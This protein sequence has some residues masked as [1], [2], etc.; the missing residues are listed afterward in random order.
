MA[1][2]NYDFN[3][4]ESPFYIESRQASFVHM[5]EDYDALLELSKPILEHRALTELEKDQLGLR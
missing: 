4:P 3:D 5:I 1:N 2:P